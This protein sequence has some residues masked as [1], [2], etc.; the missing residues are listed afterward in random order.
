VAHAELLE[1]F[2]AVPAAQ[3]AKENALDGLGQFVSDHAAKELSTESL[4]FAKTAPDENVIGID[5]FAAGFG[6]GAEAPDIADVVLS[7]GIR[8]ACEVD[9]HGLIELKALF[10]VLDQFESMALGVGLSIFAIT[11][12]GAGHDSAGKVRLPRGEACFFERPFEC[13]NEGIGHIRD[14]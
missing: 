14:N 2:A 7:A 10:Q 4:I 5:A 9:V 6:F 12:A 3:I 8:A 13:L 11:V 1:C